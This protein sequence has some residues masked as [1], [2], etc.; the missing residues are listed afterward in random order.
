MS[1]P[2]ESMKTTPSEAEE[3]FATGYRWEPTFADRERIVL[4]TV[5]GVYFTIVAI[6]GGLG[7][8]DWNVL[9]SESGDLLST[10]WAESPVIGHKYAFHWF[11]NEWL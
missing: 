5:E 9:D 11:E 6:D 7:G 4:E 2:Q 10:G 3:M 1:E 8:Y